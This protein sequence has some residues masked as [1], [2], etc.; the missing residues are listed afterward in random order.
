[1]GWISREKYK[2]EGEVTK[3][4]GKKTQYLWKMHGNW[5]SKV[6]KTKYMPDSFERNAKLDE[7][8]TTLVFE[9]NPY[10]E[11]SEFMYGLSHFSL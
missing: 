10:P 11:N 4:V 9:K 2:V 3:Q 6:F 1:M 7:S 8:T 5:H